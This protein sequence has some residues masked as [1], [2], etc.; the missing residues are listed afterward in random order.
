MKKFK[1]GLHKQK[2]QYID[3]SQEFV[4]EFS[5][6]IT[7][8]T[9]ELGALIFLIIKFDKDIFPLILSTV[10]L[11][12]WFILKRKNISYQLDNIN[13]LKNKLSEEFSEIKNVLGDDDLV[14]KSEQDIRIKLQ[15]LKKC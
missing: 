10:I 11:I 9:L 15:K 4:S 5:N 7:N 1:E 6:K 3:Y 13:D 8:L 12:S 14:K 2:Q